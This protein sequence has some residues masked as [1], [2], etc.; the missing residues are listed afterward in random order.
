M[1]GYAMRAKCDGLE[2][3]L[4]PY[5]P[6]EHER[7]LTGMQSYEVL[8][9]TS[10]RRAFTAAESAAYLERLEA[11]LDETAWAIC[12]VA[13][14]AELPVGTTSLEVATD[15]SYLA[16]SGIVI[17]DRD[18]WRKGVATLAHLARTRYAFEVMNLVA[19]TSGADQDNLGSCRALERIGYCQV[20]VNYHAGVMNGRV[21]HANKYLLINPAEGPWRFFWGETATSESFE[22]ARELTRAALARAAEQVEY[23]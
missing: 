5:R 21:V 8:G 19:I 17:Y 22:I 16:E 18:W 6:G 1:Y 2:L 23:L 11:S 7:L 3:V 13:N 15:R 12:V 4:R 9:H 10:F 20:G 14:D